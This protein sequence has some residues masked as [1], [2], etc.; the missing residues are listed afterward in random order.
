MRARSERDAL[1]AELT[2]AGESIA[3]AEQDT[4]SL[5]R[6][7]AAARARL[8]ALPS[9]GELDAALSAGRALWL[10]AQKLTAT[11]AEEQARTGDAALAL[12]Q[13]QRVLER[14]QSER[15]SKHARS[16][17][18]EATVRIHGAEDLHERAQR[19]EAEL[20]ERA[21]TLRA[22]AARAVAA[23]ELVLALHEARSE[24]QR[25]LVAP[26][27]ER[28][29]PYLESLLPGRR[30]RMDENW[31]VVGLGVGDVEEDF[32][33]LSGGAREQVSIL[34]RIALA[35]VLGAEEP[36]PVVLDDAFVN[37]DR[38]RLGE[39]M[40]ILYRASRRQQILLF[41]CHDEGFDR[42]GE[43]RRFDLS[44]KTPPLRQA[45]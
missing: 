41:S 13:E 38:A 7:R 4:A 34:V 26:V 8:G 18:L 25:R 40:R 28:A 37:T 23:R 22:V 27:V 44:R 1:R 31:S 11:L 16:I 42:L 30:L 3:R 33:D 2:R 5:D 6:E 29:R 35:E 17:H 20:D 32:H 43:T 39:M 19:A 14:L 36:I 21:Q 12:E 15:S 24:A 10:D 45:P 9:R